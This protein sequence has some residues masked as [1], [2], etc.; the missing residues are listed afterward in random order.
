MIQ[1]ELTSL[2][3]AAEG[4]LTDVSVSLFSG[5][6]SVYLRGPFENFLRKMEREIRVD[7]TFLACI[8]RT[9]QE[10]RTAVAGTETQKGLCTHENAPMEQQC[11]RQPSESMS[12]SHTDQSRTGHFSW[13][14]SARPGHT[15]DEAL[16]KSWPVRVSGAQARNLGG[17]VGGILCFQRAPSPPACWC[18][19]ALCH[20]H[21]GPCHSSFCQRFSQY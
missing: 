1:G 20:G 12:G 9:E 14:L 5:L 6:L 18:C 10:R 17:C 3:L 4:V 15:K 16:M 21:G 7:T 2:F 8:G 11:R 13:Y 19:N